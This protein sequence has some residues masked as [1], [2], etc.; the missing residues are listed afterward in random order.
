MKRRE[1][2]ALLGGAATALPTVTRAQ[3]ATEMRRVAMLVGFAKSGSGRYM[4]DCF[5]DGLGDLG[6]RD[7]KNLKLDVRWTDGIADRYP[8]LAAELVGSN[9]DLLVVTST[10]A[11]QALQR[12][13]RDIATIFMGVSD[14]VASGIVSSLSRPGGNI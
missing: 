11:T 8:P 5:V 9:P 3:Q 7:G 12:A 14:P 2:M 13:T 10:P 6:W 1:F 4:I